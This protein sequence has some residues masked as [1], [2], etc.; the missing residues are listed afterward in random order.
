MNVGGG[1]ITAVV[2]ETVGLP[3]E[4]FLIR[5]IFLDTRGPLMI[6]AES[7]WGFRV[8]VLTQGHDISNG[9]VGAVVDKGVVVEKGAWIGSGAL[10]NNCHIR[11]G[12]IVA[13]G[14]VVRSQ[15]VEPYTMVEGNPARVIK[16][17]DEA[18]RE[19]ARV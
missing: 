11:E 16:R 5:G 13:A 14:A 18:R 1:C 15:T 7:V 19:W 3:A 8:M 4:Y 12:A 17:W 9:V 6:D 10:L 2:P